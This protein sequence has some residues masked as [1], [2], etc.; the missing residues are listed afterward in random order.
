MWRELI[1]ISGS[2]LSNHLKSV[3]RKFPIGVDRHNHIANICL[4]I[5]IYSVHYCVTCIFF[6]YF[7]IDCFFP[8]FYSGFLCAC[9]YVYLSSFRQFYMYQIS[10]L[11]TTPMQHYSV[12][13]QTMTC[14][15]RM[16]HAR[17]K[18]SWALHKCSLNC[19]FA[20]GFLLQLP[21]SA[22][23]ATPYHQ[24]PPCCR[25]CSSLLPSPYP[26]IRPWL[27]QIWQQQ[28]SVRWRREGSNSTTTHSLYMQFTLSI[29]L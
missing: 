20:K 26:L 17:F 3:Q 8:K 12:L 29:L 4:W 28:K 22:D 11:H 15:Y 18:Q 16:A 21:L 10:R 19:I 9:H 27:L 6:I 2:V 7:F 23:P 1:D 25:G 24:L 14:M 5:Q 13:G